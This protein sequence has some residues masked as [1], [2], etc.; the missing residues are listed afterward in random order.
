MDERRK[1]EL[2]LAIVKVTLREQFSFRNFA[3]IKRNI[4]NTIKDPEFVAVGATSA[5]LLD[6]LKIL[7][8]EIFEEQLKT[9]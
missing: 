1:G 3:N 6:F 8:K 4:G 9:L 5:E 2:A 7:I